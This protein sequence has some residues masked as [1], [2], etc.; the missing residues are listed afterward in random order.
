MVA[1]PY[2]HW[3][4]SSGRKEMTDVI[5]KAMKRHL[6]DTQPPSTLKELKEALDELEQIRNTKDDD[7]L[8]DD[9]A[10]SYSSAY[11]SS[12]YTASSSETSVRRTRRTRRSRSPTRDPDVDW[13][14][15]VASEM[16]GSEKLSL[17]GRRKRIQRIAKIA[18]ESC[19][20]DEK[21][22]LAYMFDDVPL[23]FRRTLDQYYY[24]NLLTTEARD[25]DQVVTRYFE[26]TLRDKSDEN[27][28]LMVDQLW[29]WILDEGLCS[30]FDSPF[31]N[32]MR[33]I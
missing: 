30:T 17:Q 33:I 2:I 7:D 11:W 32:I 6:D 28:L 15:R 3:E 23:H 27:L 1:L 29:L 22:I 10:T 21:L 16:L 12:Y 26:K 19:T 24:Y 18:E 4:T 8:E 31:N 13:M 5:V 20:S 14:T 9:E 25:T